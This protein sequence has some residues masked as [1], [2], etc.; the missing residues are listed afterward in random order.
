MD[1]LPLILL[2]TLL[3]ILVLSVFVLFAIRRA[4]QS[5]RSLIRHEVELKRRMYELAVMKEVE[6]RIGYSL[7]VPKIVSIITGSLRKLLPYST[8]T[9][10]LINETG[11]ATFKCEIEE[12]VGADFVAAVKEQMLSELARL[13][14]V[15][16][17]RWRVEETVTGAVLSPDGPLKPLSAFNLPLDIGGKTVGLINVASA[18]SGVYGAEET[19]LLTR[20]TQQAS[21]AL[22]KLQGVLATEKG[23]V[24]SLIA[25]MAEGVIMTDRDTKLVVINPAAKAMLRITQDE[26][27]IFDVVGSLTGK[28]DL[29]TRLEESIKSRK[30]LTQDELYLADKVLQVLVSPVKDGEDKILGSV[31]LFHDVTNEKRLERLRQD[32]TA[33]MVHELRAPLTA[34][35][36][37][38]DTILRHPK[39]L[40]GEK[41]G[42]S[43]RLIYDSSTQMLKLVGDL[44]DVAK[45][46][47]G[48]FEIIEETADLR[49]LLQEVL[50]SFR[51]L[52]QSKGLTL[53][54]VIDDDL[55]STVDFDKMRISQVLNNLLANAFKF[56][57]AGGIKLMAQVQG[58]EV[59]VSVR[60]S[61]E[62]IPH[63]D[64]PDLFNKF[65]Q[66][67]TSR[68]GAGTGLGLVISKGIVESHGGRIWVGSELGQ[69][70]TF[71]FSLPLR[72][73]TPVVSR[74]ATSPGR[75]TRGG[76]SL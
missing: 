57:V 52:A 49:P 51:P 72:S 71:Y 69:G 61:G 11:K 56:T 18:Q 8:V 25:S 13:T 29:R 43:V 68:G 66:L 46:E 38:A 33:M 54:A 20:I 39:E 42:V 22:A 21:Q 31:V 23:K 34:M 65:K 62:G 19:N 32:F 45:I 10:L 73:S 7:D 53:E 59:V 67:E 15:E 28:F 64:L 27:T 41:L 9:S 3:P 74:G 24:V 6:E 35:K 17:G 44:L 12:S 75:F 76:R 63:Q 50:E 30:P 70:S 16:A 1:F 48:K 14:K 4:R 36:G 60:D 58:S 2:L 40:A 37:T 26:V 47:A 55:P 5:Q